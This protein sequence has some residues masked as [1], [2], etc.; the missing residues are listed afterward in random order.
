MD[1]DAIRIALISDIHGNLPAFE[2]VVADMQREKVDSVAF[3]GD[4]VFLGLYPQECHDLL[5]SLNP[6]CCIKGNTDANLEELPFFNPTDED[7]LRIK[8]FIEYASIR[9]DESAKTLL[10][11]RCLAQRIEIQS[12]SLMFCHGS[13]YSFKHQLEP[14][15]PDFPTISQRIVEEGLDAVF[16]GH[17]HLPMQFQI[18][19]TLVC[20]PGAVGYSFDGD[21][22]A[23]YG[24]LTLGESVTCDI[25]RVDYDI[26][27]YRREVRVQKPPF[28]DMLLHLLQTGR[29]LRRS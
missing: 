24:I 18:G 17:I 23:S 20:N 9:L 1:V 13:P 28:I 14:R 19:S 15:N 7:G 26:E 3:L 8:Q 12:R 4:L 27:R 6:M 2:S 22:R 21:V 29:P 25:R 11:G 16:C 10:V 5:L